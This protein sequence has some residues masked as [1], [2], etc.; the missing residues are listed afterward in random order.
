MKTSK[1]VCSQE[2]KEVF[3][4]VLDLLSNIFC[5]WE[6]EEI[7]ECKTQTKCTKLRQIDDKSVPI[8]KT[9]V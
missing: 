8:E 5:V 4:D 2:L 6:K 3:E 1:Y 7:K 9:H